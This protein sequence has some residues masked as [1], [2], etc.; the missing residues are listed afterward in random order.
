MTPTTSIVAANAEM[1][2]AVD[3]V[4]ELVGLQ[5]SSRVLDGVAKSAEKKGRKEKGVTL[6]VEN[7]AKV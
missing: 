2:E 4:E 1:K 3:M 6:C 7:F 5:M